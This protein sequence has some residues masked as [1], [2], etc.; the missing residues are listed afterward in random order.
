MD[1]KLLLSG[2]CGDLYGGLGD[3]SISGGL[4]D[5][6]G[7]L[8]YMSKREGLGSRSKVKISEEQ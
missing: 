8:A 6:P 3:F 1:A 7:E 2:R 4:L 5:N